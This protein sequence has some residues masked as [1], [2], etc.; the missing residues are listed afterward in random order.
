MTQCSRSHTIARWSQKPARS[1]QGSR[2]TQES[3]RGKRNAIASIC[4]RFSTVQSVQGSRAMS[5]HEDTYL[6]DILY[7]IR[8][9]VGQYSCKY[10]QTVVLNFD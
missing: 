5:R 6:D 4:C 2:C 7:V 8:E 3:G 10:F 9:D 1:A